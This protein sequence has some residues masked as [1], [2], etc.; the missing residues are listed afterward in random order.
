MSEPATA[1]ENENGQRKQT[2]QKIKNCHP[3]A[4]LQ[5]KSFFLQCCWNISQF[6][7]SSKFALLEQHT[8]KTQKIIHKASSKLF[9]SFVQNFAFFCVCC[10]ILFDG[11]NAFPFV[12]CA[13]VLVVHFLGGKTLCPRNRFANIWSPRQFIQFWKRGKGTA[14]GSRSI[15][16]FR[17]ICARPSS[18][19]GAARGAGTGRPSHKACLRRCRGVHRQGPPEPRRV[20]RVVVCVPYPGRVFGH[21]SPAAFPHSPGLGLGF[22]PKFRPELYNS[23]GCTS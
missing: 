4:L 9:G 19:A 7:L 15:L 21:Q 11:S 20:H 16:T 2:L 3:T 8:F 13:E 10:D 14:T 18:T 5:Y 17:C 6:L 22:R 1:N 23:V 12:L